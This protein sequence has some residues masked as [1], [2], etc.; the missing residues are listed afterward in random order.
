MVSIKT[1]QTYSE[2]DEFLNLLDEEQRNKIPKKLRAFFKEEKD[3]SYHKNI[4]ANIEI[5]KQN[6]KEETLALIAFLNLQY[7]C[8][9]KEEKER[10]QQIYAQNER[11][12]QEMLHEKYD[13]TTIFKK[14]NEVLE[15][16]GNVV[17]DNLKLVEYKEPIFKKIINKI[18]N[19]LH[20]K[21]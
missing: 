12:Y 11:V 7:L 4:D 13:P 5:E 19:F 21:K 10:L 20:I 3:N 17:E 1:K 8:D 15:E 14:K 2:I 16:K 18:L 9:N 6:L